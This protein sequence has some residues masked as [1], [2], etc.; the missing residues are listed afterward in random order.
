MEEKA[1]L[2]TFHDEIKKAFSADPSFQTVAFMIKDGKLQMRIPYDYEKTLKKAATLKGVLDKISFII[3]KP[4][5]KTVNAETISRSEV[6]GRL[7]PASF[8][9]TM[10][11]AALWRKKD[12]GMAPEYVY[13]DENEDT[14]VSYENLFVCLLINLISQDVSSLYDDLVPIVPCFEEREEKKGIS[15]GK[16]SP[17]QDFVPFSYPYKG[18]YESEKSAPSRA[19]K[20]LGKLT[21]ILK[22]IKAT[23]FYRL[24]S[25]E[26]GISGEIALTNILLHDE[27]YNALY[28]FYVG[29]YL[30]KTAS[31]NNLS[32]AEYY[33]YA[34][35]ELFY[36]L[37]LEEGTIGK[38]IKCHFIDK[39][40]RLY[41]APFS[42]KKGLLDYSFYED[43]SSLAIKIEAR[44][45]LK[46]AGG[47]KKELAS[48][49]LLFSKD[50]DEVNGPLLEKA[51]AQS[52]E[53]SSAVLVSMNNLSRRFD[54]VLKIT[55]YDDGNEKRMR[56]LLSSLGM[57]FECEGSLFKD[58]CPVCGSRG[59]S[60]E[61]AD[62]ICPSCGSH[63][64]LLGEKSQYLWIK[65][66][67]RPSHD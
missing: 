49:T 9:K 38:K 12:G 8:Q 20:A 45:S 5:L 18:R 14:I 37:T 65:S 17:F 2:S 13:H 55:Y 1:F 54:H 56:N 39:D 33:D 47:P 21:K 7:L 44:S 42:F 64:V 19:I 53:D 30:D 22:N 15:F 11:D 51:L 16:Q 34:L 67:R 63:Y 31:A 57:L 41:F 58:I 48:Y 43:P 10:R 25:A 40:R 66:F 4:K 36:G 6:G 24:L 23:E 61:G 35:V 46:D 26:K 29:H 52:G 62:Y 60:N 32:N 59:P 3:Y 27:V 28:R 50:Y